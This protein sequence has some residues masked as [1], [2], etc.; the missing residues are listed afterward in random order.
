MWYEWAQCTALPALFTLGVLE[1]PLTNHKQPPPYHHFILAY[2]QPAAAPAQRATPSYA[3]NLAV[4]VYIYIY[5]YE[6]LRA[7]S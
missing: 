7:T 4:A 3:T 5:I 6:G 1:L 2:R